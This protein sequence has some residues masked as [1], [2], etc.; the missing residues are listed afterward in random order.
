[1]NYKVKYK[2]IHH[3]WEY[4]EAESEEEAIAKV[5]EE[6]EM[7]LAFEVGELMDWGDAQPEP[8]KVEEDPESYRAVYSLIGKACRATDRADEAL[9]RINRIKR[10]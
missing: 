3:F 2:E 7:R 6:K 5:K 4:V 10:L 9:R 8:I 1:M